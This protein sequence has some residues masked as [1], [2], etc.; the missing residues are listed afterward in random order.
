MIRT[1][2]PSELQS[3]RAESGAELDVID[4]RER[5]EWNTGHVP[6]ARLVPLEVLRADPK[7]ALLRDTTTSVVLVCAKGQ[8][9]ATAARVA[10]GLGFK[11]VFSLEGG[12]QAWVAAGL[13]IIMPVVEPKAPRK[14]RSVE[15][16]VVVDPA[17]EPG[18]DAIVG[19]N[20]REQRTRRGFTLDALARQAGVS[21]ALLG[22]IEIGRT[23]PSIGVVWKIAQSLGVPFSVLLSTQDRTETSVLRKDRSKRLLSA[24]GRF[25]SRAL[26]PLAGQRTTEFYELW[27]APHGREEA[28]AHQ[29]GTRENII[30]TVGRLEIGFSQEK[31]LLET[32][33]ALMFSADVPHTYTNPD[34]ADCWMNLVMT[35]AVP[36]G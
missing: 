4:V 1:L 36:V 13:P 20:L 23:V 9:S 25:S 34:N 21:R 14:G 8:R 28:D 35:Y 12:T 3:L 2:S 22:Q 27:L 5:S 16:A 18:F 17:P 15:A 26:F 6:G 33:D 30:V 19:A 29:P 24:D 31:I 10:E 11:A 32:G 7:A